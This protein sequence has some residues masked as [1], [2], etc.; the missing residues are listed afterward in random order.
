MQSRRFA[1]S[2]VLIL[3]LLAVFPACPSSSSSSPHVVIHPQN[4][5]PIHVAVEVVDTPEKRRL[6]LMY[7]NELPEFSGM[8]FIFP[9]EHPL[10][11]WMK[12]TPLPLDIIYITVDSTIVSIAENTTP[13]SEA[14]IPSKHPAKYTLEV[15]GGFCHRHAIVAGDR[16]EFVQVASKLR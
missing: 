15:N 1:R 8:L 16:V 13:Y 3:L 4:G 9:Q 5:E 14:Q 10:N 12:N 2:C 6:G 7:R 11:F